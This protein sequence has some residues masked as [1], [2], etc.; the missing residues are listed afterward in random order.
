M[1][2]YKPNKVTYWLAYSNDKQTIQY[3]ITNPDQVTTSGAENFE[4]DIDKNKLIQ[5]LID[6]NYKFI[7]GE[8]NAEI[9][10]IIKTTNYIFNSKISKFVEN[11]VFDETLNIFSFE[12]KISIQQ[13]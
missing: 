12:S 8:T 6:L 7:D 3:G 2:I 5:R 1:E 4:Y 9:I 13:K 10:P 11:N